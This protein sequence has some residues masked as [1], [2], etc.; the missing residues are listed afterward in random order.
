MLGV[1][2]GVGR[3][4]LQPFDVVLPNIGSELVDL[5]DRGADSFPRP[6]DTW[7]SDAD[8]LCTSLARLPASA[9]TV[10]SRGRAAARIVFPG[11]S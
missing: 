9:M 11:E 8:S 4:L 5:G 7:V 1:G 2:S 6:L 3:T 10:C